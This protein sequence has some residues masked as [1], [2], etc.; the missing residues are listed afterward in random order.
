MP[1]IAFLLG[2]V[3]LAR[4]D[5]HRRLPAA[6]RGAGWKV[7]VLSQEAVHLGPDGVRLGSEDPAR[8]DLIWLL[9]MGRAHT[10]FDR[11]QLLRLLRQERF[12]TGVDALVYRHAKYAWWRHMPETYASNDA[13][14]LV[15]RLAGGGEWIAK[16]AA[17]SYGRDVV[18]ISAGADGAAAIDRLTGHGG[19]QYCLMQ[20]F[21]P[22]IERGEKRTLV[23]GGRIVGS[24]LRVPGPD[25]LANLAAGGHPHP[26]SLTEAEQTL[27]EALADELTANGVG[28][29][30]VDTVFP[31]LMEVNLVNPGGLATLES[32]YGVDYAA[33]VVEALR[34]WRGVQ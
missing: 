17:G 30:A 4:H 2:D 12:V 31:H 13:S 5:N 22:E 20:R 29:A 15:A 32:L 8:F 1:E 27:V 7:T 6:F 26:T 3:A 28:F 10:F 19:G 34:G 33:V 21:V 24:Y 14:Y 18:R 23:A 16:P 11:M 9:G 25:L